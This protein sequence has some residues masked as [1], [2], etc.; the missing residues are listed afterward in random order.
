VPRPEKRWKEELDR[1]IDLG[2]I[3]SYLKKAKNGKAVDVDGYP[4]E[5]WK[6]VGKIENTSGILVKI[7]NK[8]YEIGEVPSGWKTSMMHMIYKEKG[9]KENPAN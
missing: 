9:S 4:M 7:M 8:I 2:E 5:F 3:H 6:E 1:E